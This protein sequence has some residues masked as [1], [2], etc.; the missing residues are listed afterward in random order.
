MSVQASNHPVAVAELALTVREAWLR[1]D[2][3]ALGDYGGFAAFLARRRFA[4]LWAASEDRAYGDLVEAAAK[5]GVGYK[6]LH[7]LASV[8]RKI[9]LSR[10]RD[11]LSW[12]HHAA[13]AA[14][15]VEIGDKLLARAEAEGWSR[16]RMR[17]EARA[18]R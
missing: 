10:R 6:T 11:K 7:N 16:T 12:S 15:P 4:C 1:Q 9:D 13:V 8:A 14:L 2:R 5:I 3:W 17:E 18:R